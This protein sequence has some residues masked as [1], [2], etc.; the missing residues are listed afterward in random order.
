M[1]MV[2]MMKG[3]VI[4]LPIIRYSGRLLYPTMI[5]PRATRATSELKNVRKFYMV[6]RSTGGCIVYWRVDTSVI[7]L[8]YITR[9]SVDVKGDDDLGLEGRSVTITDERCASIRD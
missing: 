7:A 9:R 2:M 8:G 1:V 6:N 4:L 5:F 3:K